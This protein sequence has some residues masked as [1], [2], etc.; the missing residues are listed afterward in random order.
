MAD[1]VAELIAQSLKIPVS[2]VV[3]TLEYQEISEWDSMG[4]LDLIL[5]LEQRLGVSINDEMFPRLTTV[6]AIR[7]FV[8]DRL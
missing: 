7:E 5:A 1:A 2:K 3:D 4:H 8:A 6:R